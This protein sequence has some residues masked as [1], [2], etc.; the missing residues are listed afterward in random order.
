M[1]GAVLLGREQP[2]DVT[3]GRLGRPRDRAQARPAVLARDQPLGRR[4]DERDP[5]ELEQEEVGGRVHASQRPVHVERGGR[6]GPLRTLRRHAL[7]DVA[8]DDVALDG[9]HHLLVA[10]LLGEAP[11]RSGGAARLTV[12]WDAGLEPPLDLTRI[13]REHLG[14]PGPVVEADEGLRDDQAAVRE[15]VAVRRKLDRRLERR[16][17]VVRE[18]ADHRQPQ[19]LCLLERHEPRP[20]AHPRGTSEPAALDGLQQEAGGPHPAQAE[21]GPEGSEE[22]G[23][24]RRDAGHSS[25][26]TKETSVGGLEAK[27][28]GV[29]VVSA[30]SRLARGATTS[31]GCERKP[32][33]AH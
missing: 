1:L 17:V 25:P 9:P 4:A 5:V 33:R 3:L 11:E 20:G 28:G 16:D 10:L 23:R 8:G 14:G 12:P 18:I 22:V 13:P 7:E 30:R 21:V 19:R 29:L 27:Q 2:L 24:D 26:E 32:S 6:G 31:P 15:A